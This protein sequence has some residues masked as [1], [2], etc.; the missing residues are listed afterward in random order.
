MIGETK[1]AHRFG[2]RGNRLALL[3]PSPPTFAGMLLRPTSVAFRP[4][5]IHRTGNCIGT[6]AGYGVDT[7]A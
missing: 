2:I 6:A 1:H 7:S 3:I 4:E 5:T